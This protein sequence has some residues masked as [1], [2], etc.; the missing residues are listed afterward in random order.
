MWL[1]IKL[2]TTSQREL[3]GTPRIGG[4]LRLL[5]L[6]TDSAL[7]QPLRESGRR[8]VAADLKGSH[9]RRVVGAIA[10]TQAQFVLKLVKEGLIEDPDGPV[11]EVGAPV[12]RGRVMNTAVIH[13]HR[14]ASLCG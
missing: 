8:L 10:G 3:S 2:T 9:H 11:A 4:N 14:V 12:R 6:G 5:R 7:G 13:Y 1:R